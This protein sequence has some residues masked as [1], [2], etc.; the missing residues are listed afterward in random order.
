M[1]KKIHVGLIGLGKRGVGLLSILVK[2]E[3]VIVT[4]V[5]DA[6]ED[7]R[8]NAVDKIVS[9]TGSKP[10]YSDNYK[11]ILNRKDIDAVIVS[12]S[13]A[14][15]IN[16]VIDSMKAGKYVAF[17]VG[18]AY[19]EDECWQLVKA[20]EETG[21]PCMMLENCCYG[22]NELMVSNMVRKGV[23]GEIV[24]CRGGY[25]HDLRE[26]VAF[27]RENRHYRLINYMHRNCENY[28]THELGPIAKIL[29]INRGNRMLAL[30]SMASKARGLNEYILKNKGRQYDLADY[31][32]AQGDVETTTIRCAHG[33]TIVLT[34]DTTLPRAYSRG[35]VI[36]GTKAM[37]MEDN[38]SLFIDGVHNDYEFSWNKQWNN[39]EKYREQYEHPLWR[40]YKPDSSDSHGGMDFLVLSAFFD[41]V[42]RQVQTA[43]DVYD[44]ASWMSIAAFSEQSISMGGMP[45]PVPDFTN[46]KWLNRKPS[47]GGIY[48]LDQ[49]Y[50][51]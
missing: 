34:L 18:G 21:I 31:S 2:M 14:D 38:N 30:T 9:F 43:I 44:A 28:P 12:T 13:W 1:D 10:Y 4:A 8:L 39:M 32:F 7:R 27:G 46:G 22:R 17:E 11:D 26:E 50:E 33:E 20:Y 37:Y 5:S 49:V 3:D 41:S 42:R 40:N 25:H 15:H 6:Y 48:C 24:H 35:L 51:K 16:I 45:V 23:F 36:Q 47:P 29:N 19:S